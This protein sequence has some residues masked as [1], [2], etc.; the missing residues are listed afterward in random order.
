MTEIVCRAGQP[1]L[2]S[3][4]QT[5]AQKD[6]TRFC[7]LYC[8]GNTCLMG[9]LKMTNPTNPGLMMGVLVTL[10]DSALDQLPKG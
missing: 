4:N 5:E 10:G 6:L 8:D 3:G 7:E 1:L 2:T 9:D